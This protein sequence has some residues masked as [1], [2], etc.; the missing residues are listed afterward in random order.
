[1]YVN[2]F[3]MRRSSQK[4]NQRK[5]KNKRENKPHNPNA[6]TN[7]K[8][9][10]QNTPRVQCKTLT[11]F[12]ARTENIRNKCE[13]HRMNC[14]C[15][16][17]YRIDETVSKRSKKT[18]IFI[19]IL[20]CSAVSTGDP[21]FFF[22]LRAEC[23][24]APFARTADNGRWRRVEIYSR[25]W[26]FDWRTLV[27]QR[28][29]DVRRKMYESQTSDERVDNETNEFGVQRMEREWWRP[30]AFSIVFFFFWL[31]FILHCECFAWKSTR[32]CERSPWNNLLTIPKAT[33]M[34]HVLWWIEI[35]ISWNKLSKVP[36]LIHNYY[37]R[38]VIVIVI[39][40]LFLASRRTRPCCHFNS[41]SHR[42]FPH[43]YIKTVVKLAERVCVCMR[44]WSDGCRNQQHCNRYFGPNGA[45]FLAHFQIC[46]FSH[47]FDAT[48]GS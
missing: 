28:Q 9:I 6:N 47:L 16:R 10:L 3:S 31:R 32:F 25:K 30:M 38:A 13:I 19:G 8:K 41:I 46:A 21:F 48:N 42:I 36:A 29:M 23:V 15:T 43:V 45:S 24:A 40:I 2:C 35:G 4:T 17:D 7:E 37:C 11:I 33:S 12:S 26:A 20:C 1:M 34:K 18:T 14:V 44:R 5:W 22:S 27:R 39:Y